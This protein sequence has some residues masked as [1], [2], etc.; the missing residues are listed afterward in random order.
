[1]KIIVALLLLVTSEAL[2][3]PIT[4]PTGRLWSDTVAWQTTQEFA[5]AYAEE[6]DLL[7]LPH[8][9][10]HILVYDTKTGIR[11]DT[12]D[13]LDVFGRENVV[14]HEIS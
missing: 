6:A 13:L 14:I 8:Q 2:A 4:I 1:M 5:Y 10:R 9:M 7:F 11:T 3:Q 12:I